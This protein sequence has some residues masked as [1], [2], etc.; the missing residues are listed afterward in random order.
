MAEP[1]TFNEPWGVAVGPDGSVYVADTWNNR[2]QKFT[3]E[4]N[5]VTLWGQFGAA[6]SEVHFWGPRGIAVDDQG[7]VF[8]T[9][10]GNKRVVIFDSDGNPLT[11]FGGAG[12]G[13]GQFDE[14]VG[15]EVDDLGRV[16]VADTWNKRIQVLIPDGDSLTYPTHTTWDIEGWYGD[17]LDNKPFLAIDEQ[18]NVY[19]ADPQMGRVLIFDVQGNFLQTFGAYGSGASEIG[20]VSGLAVDAQGSIWVSDGGNNRLMH[21]IL[22]DFSDVE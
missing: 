20:I 8:I 4:G 12:M 21:F 15:I 6:E 14:P 18:Y 22:P 3:A 19:V 17:S 13:V 1:G 11:S 9:D 10:T 7:R 2:I 16:Y 5:F